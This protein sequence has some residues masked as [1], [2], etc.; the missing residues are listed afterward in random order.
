MR[1]A[2]GFTILLAVLVFST[3]CPTYKKIRTP[4][5]RTL[6]TGVV[7]EANGSV[8]EHVTVKAVK[9]GSSFNASTDTG[10]DGSFILD[11]LETGTY[12]IT[13]SLDGYSPSTRET[14]LL[15]AG[16]QTKVDFELK[17]IA[18]P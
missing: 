7:K 4:G 18:S 14:K 11:A 13:A 16:D 10:P 15:S 6:V 17:K 8:L 12:R 1:R 2:V 9:A 5:D 3:A